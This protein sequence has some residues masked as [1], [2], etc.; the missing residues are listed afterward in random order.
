M[1]K[2][3]KRLLIKARRN[4]FGELSGNNISSRSGDGFDFY[5]LRP[6]SYGEDVR[7]IDWKRSAKM[8]EPFVKLFHEEREIQI[9]IVP[10]LSGSLQF[11]IKRL[12]QDVVA[13]IV[14]LLG[15]SALKN[16]DR[17]SI[18]TCKNK[19]VNATKLSKKESNLFQSVESIINENLLGEKPQIKMLN[20]FI[21]KRYKRRSLVVFIGD[22]WEIPKFNVLAK[23]HEILAINVRDRFEENPTTL[24]QINQI[25]PD[26]LV[27]SNIFLDKQSVKNVKRKVSLHD[28]QL[29]SIFTKQR[30]R[31]QKIYTD[32]NV[33]GKLYH[34]LRR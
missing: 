18:I 34:F 25:N 17:Y 15:F 30:V 22:F 21:Q 9:L 23:K 5:E 2:T 7:R 33:Y 32:E 8:N 26:T 6:Y 24:G 10:I 28:R 19:I 14:A 31:M 13:E 29:H 1:K 16:A 20:E 4:I 3:T 27:S 12:K 11:G